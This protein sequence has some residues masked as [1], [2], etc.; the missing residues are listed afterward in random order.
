MTG[1]CCSS[2]TAS[3][4]FFTDERSA[5]LSCQIVMKPSS[6]GHGSCGRHR[7]G[8][9]QRRDRCETVVQFCP[10]V[11]RQTASP[12]RTGHG[13]EPSRGVESSWSQSCSQQRPATQLIYAT[14]AP[15]PRQGADPIAGVH[16]NT[17]IV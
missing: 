13:V 16:C 4:M 15:A 6:S 5:M 11:C 3:A 10:T 8:W 12:S 14:R 2:R 1:G 9:Y 7:H 17:Y